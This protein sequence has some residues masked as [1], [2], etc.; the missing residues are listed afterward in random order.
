MATKRKRA[1]AKKPAN[2]RGKKKVEESD[3]E[4]DMSETSDMDQQ[5][6][7]DEVLIAGH[8][9]VLDTPSKLPEVNRH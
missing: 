6:Q 7:P 1:P 8:G 3:M 9:D 4:S 5:N 2:K